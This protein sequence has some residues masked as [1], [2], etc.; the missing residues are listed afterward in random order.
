MKLT[1]GAAR[2]FAGLAAALVFASCGPQGASEKEAA[3][4]PTE[5]ASASAEPAVPE[6]VNGWRE[7]PLRDG[8]I[9]IQSAKWKTETITI[10]I[11]ANGELEYKLAMKK[12]EAI[13]YSISYGDL[14][15]PG[16]MVSEFHGHTP[17]G[18]DGNGDLMFYSKT[19]GA[20]QHGSFAAPWDGIHGW[21]LKN[22]SGKP[23]AVKLEVAGFYEHTS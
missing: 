13:V 17:K 12:D 14:E 10:P 18:S 1:S 2:S 4:T 16:L 11:A 22:D 20:T 21:Y 23:V 8:V 5:T 7:Y 6:A 19:G 9:Q 15:H 3:A